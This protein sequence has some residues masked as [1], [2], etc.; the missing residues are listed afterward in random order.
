MQNWLIETSSPE[1]RSKLFPFMRE[2]KFKADFVKLPK[3][4]AHV[5]IDALIPVSNGKNDER[6]ARRQ[7]FGRR[8]I[9]DSKMLDGG[10]S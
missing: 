5:K 9:C 7:I 6:D 10:T 1:K 2:I 3:T 4:A 8:Q